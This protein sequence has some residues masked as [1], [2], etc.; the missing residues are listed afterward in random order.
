METKTNNVAEIYAELRKQY[1]D[2]EIAESFVFPSQLTPEQRKQEYDRLDRLFRAKANNRSEAEIIRSGVTEMYFRFLQYLRQPK[3]QELFSF[4]HQLREYLHTT[5]R[6]QKQFG[7]ELDLEKSK[8]SKLLN[9]KANP[10]PAL[11]FRLE[12]HS[13]GLLPARLWY[14]LHLR[15]L[16]HRMM[17]N[18]ELKQAEFEKVK[19]TVSL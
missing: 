15:E 17:Q 9:G 7:A 18:E 11:C 13:D 2:Q 19:T 1:T 5:R 12:K 8:L 14:R 10:T 3:F 4:A 6:N 16:E